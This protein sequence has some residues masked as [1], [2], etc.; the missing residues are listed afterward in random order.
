MELTRKN[1]NLNFSSS[2]TSK[3]KEPNNTQDTQ[4][5]YKASHPLASQDD[6]DGSTSSKIID[7]KNDHDS[8]KYGSK[9]D[10]YITSADDNNHKRNNNKNLDEDLEIGEGGNKKGGI[11]EETPLPLFPLFVLTI[12]L[13]S[14]PMCSTIILPFVYFMVRDFHVTDNE[15]EIGFYAGLI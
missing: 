6:L 10:G 9:N 5:I 13:F 7:K 2:P 12:V 15:K 14:E 1:S 8:E 11:I 3:G 4:K